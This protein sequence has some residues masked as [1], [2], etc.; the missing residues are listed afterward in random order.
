MTVIFPDVELHFTGYLRT[1]LA[2]RSEP[3]AANV[4]VGVIA[5]T[6]LP[7]RLVTIRR[8]GGGDLDQVREQARLTVNVWHETHQQAVDL[9]RLVRALL[10]AS[11]NG[12]PVLRVETNAGP[13][14]VPEENDKPHLTMM[15]DAWIRGE[16]L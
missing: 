15:I 3:F 12:D 7:P 1:A 6:T 16:N 11:P 14:V 5:P 4:K 10:W 9:T 13:S 2:A 8:D